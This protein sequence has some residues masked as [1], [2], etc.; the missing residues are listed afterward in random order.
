M[1]FPFHGY[2]IQ[3]RWSKGVVWAGLRRLLRLNY[4][5][6]MMKPPTLHANPIPPIREPA[7]DVLPLPVEPDKGPVPEP[8]PEDPE[9][10]KVID[11]AM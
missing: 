5:E 10:E 1:G 9:R 7:P 3:L 4:L 6:W 8:L 2:S 11:P